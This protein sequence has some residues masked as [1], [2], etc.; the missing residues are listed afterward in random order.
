MVKLHPMVK[1]I[2][3]LSTIVVVILVWRNFPL[4]RRVTDIQLNLK[5]TAT[6]GSPTPSIQINKP[7]ISKVIP[8]K[9]HVFQTFNNCGPAT[10][11]MLLSY[12]GIEVSQNELGNKLRPYQNPQG[13]NDDKS[14]TLEELAQESKNYKLVPFHR[15]NGSIELLKLLIANDIPVIVRTL[16]HPNEDIGHYRLIRGFDDYTKEIIQDDSY[17]NKNLHFAYAEFASLWQPFNYEY[18][19][20]VPQDKVRTVNIILGKD[21]DANK[22]WENAYQRAKKET[23]QDSAAVFPIFNQAVALYHLKKY[24]DS[25][26]SYESIQSQ[27]P[28]RMLWYQIEPIQS[29]LVLENYQKVFE[30]TDSILNNENRAYTELYLIRGAAYAQQGNKEAAKEEYEKAVFYNVNDQKAQ[31][32]L[33]SI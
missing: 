5:V 31:L 7:E 30:L 4:S 2:M 23:Q 16:L 1:I 25:V 10:L 27:L 12:Y 29:Y 13:D 17:E 21:I 19:I 6:I 24:Q 14:V 15:P 9:T 32:V 33:N 20:I 28:R 3:A 11:S 26:Q 8:Q 18:L 22:A